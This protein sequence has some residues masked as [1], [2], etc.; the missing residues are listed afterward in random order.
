MNQHINELLAKIESDY[1]VKI[2]F[3]VEAGS[4]AWGFP[5]INSDHDPRFTYIKPIQ[6]Y[7]TLDKQRDTIERTIDEIDLVGWDLKKALTLF[8]KTNPNFI[9]WLYSPINYQTNL[10]HDINLKEELLLCLPEYINRQG[11]IHHYRG[12]A[13]RNWKAYLQGDEIWTKKYLYVIRPML[14]CIWLEYEQTAPPVVFDDLIR[15]TVPYLMKQLGSKTHDILYQIE[16]LVERKKAGEEL[17]TGP[18]IPALHNFIGFEMNHYQS[19]AKTVEKMDQDT[20]KAFTNHLTQLF[21]NL[22][23]FYTAE[24][25]APLLYKHRT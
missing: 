1:E 21:H 11:M 10:H 15:G 19:Y 23:H 16:E 9:E 3:A 22:L 24:D 2:L 14:A 12:M 5:S 8:R 20:S 4:R 17:D 7:L 18:Q 6:E 13:E 25:I